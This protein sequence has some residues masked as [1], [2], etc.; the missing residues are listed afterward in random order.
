MGDIKAKYYI[1]DAILLIFEGNKN[2]IFSSGNIL[3]GRVNNSFTNVITHHDA[4]KLG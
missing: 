1:S 4:L 3:F 2:G